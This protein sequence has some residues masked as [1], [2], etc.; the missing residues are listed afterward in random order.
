MTAYP[1]NLRLGTLPM[2]SPS[3]LRRKPAYL[4]PHTPTLYLCALM[5]PPQGTACSR[6][7]K[8]PISSDLAICPTSQTSPPM[9]SLALVPSFHTT[10]VNS[11]QRC[12]SPPRPSVTVS[13]RNGRMCRPLR[14]DIDQGCTAGGGRASRLGDVGRIQGCGNALPA[15]AHPVREARRRERS[16]AHQGLESR[17]AG[18]LAVVASGEGLEGERVTRCMSDF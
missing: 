17:N 11:S 3:P 15:S 14:G 1:S 2:T 13:G 5:C 7:R 10:T 16:E 12:I 4:S 8:H 18:H 6:P 9:R